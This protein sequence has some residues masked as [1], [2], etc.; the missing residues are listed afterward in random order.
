MRQGLGLEVADDLLD[1][2]VIAMIDIGGQQRHLTV[3]DEAVVAPVGPQRELLGGGQ[4]GAA[5]D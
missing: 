1:L 5:N 4:T 2:G 3:G